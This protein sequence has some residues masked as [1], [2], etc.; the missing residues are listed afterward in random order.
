MTTFEDHTFILQVEKK[1]QNTTTHYFWKKVKLPPS[2]VAS[3]PA[4]QV[5]RLGWGGIWGT[6]KF[7]LD[8]GPERFEKLSSDSCTGGV[9]A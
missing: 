4:A 7:L 8:S 1:K 9:G 5:G 2:T 6:D 3:F